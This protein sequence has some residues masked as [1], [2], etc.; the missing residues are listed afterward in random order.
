MAVPVKAGSHV[1]E[2]VYFPDKL[3]PGLL[4][5]LLSLALL[6]LLTTRVDSAPV[7]GY[8]PPP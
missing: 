3:L 1:L 2:L 6:T 7:G 4:A 8:F 5:A